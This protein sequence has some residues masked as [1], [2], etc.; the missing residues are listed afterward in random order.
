VGEVEGEVA[1]LR[2]KSMRSRPRVRGQGH[3]VDQ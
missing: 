1:A 2:P 3:G